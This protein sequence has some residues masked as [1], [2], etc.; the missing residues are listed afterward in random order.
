M[1]KYVRK[2]PKKRK[3]PYPPKSNRVNY[4][5][6]YLISN[7]KT[8]EDVLDDTRSHLKS[9]V[10][11]FKTIRFEKTIN[12]V[13]KKVRADLRDENVRR[14]VEALVDGIKIIL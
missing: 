3:S 14:T 2:Y 9:D 5:A 4:Y 6:N 1:P 12:V 13:A 8:I 11:I 7:Q 10:G